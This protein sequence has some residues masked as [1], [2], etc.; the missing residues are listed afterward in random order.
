VLE[1]MNALVANLT[2]KVPLIRRLVEERDAAV[3]ERAAAIIERDMAL[4]SRDTALVELDKVLTAWDAAV[5]ERGAAI[6]ERDTA[7]AARDSAL[8]EFDKVLAAQE[9]AICAKSASSGVNAGEVIACI[10]MILGRTPDAE[11]VEYHLRLGF[12]NRFA[13]GKYMINTGEFQTLYAGAMQ[14]FR[15]ASVFLGDRV[16]TSTHRGD[17]IYLVPL[18][19]DL[20]PG[21]LRY[22]KWE[23]HV[24]QTI[25]ASLRPGDTVIDV[26]ANVGYHTLAMA[27]AVGSGGQVH[28]FEANPNVMRLLRATMFVNRFSNWM[29]LGRVTLYENAVLDR[30]GTITLASAPGHYGSG[31]VINDAPSSDYG[32]AYSTRVGVAAITLDG[33]LADRVGTVDLI[34]MDIEGSEPLALRGAQALIERSPNIKIITEWSVGMMGARADVGEYVA[35]LVK[36]GFG[37][38]LIEPGTGLTDIEPSAALTLPHCDLLLSRNPSC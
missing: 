10:E 18:D 11:L 1:T 17:A 37:F 16:L 26:G 32:P 20:T 29:G 34:H 15:H 21:I 2:Q 33:V 36:Q 12:P 9:A 35:W 19:I 14:G 31:H 38:W 23:P 6:I 8:V 13:L 25:V 7:L 22:G 30:Q 3:T 28:A 27:A 24:E 5:T 4:A